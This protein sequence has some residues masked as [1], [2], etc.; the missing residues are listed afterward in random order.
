MNLRLQEHTT[1]LAGRHN[2][3]AERGICPSEKGAQLLD[4]SQ[5]GMLPRGGHVFWHGK[6]VEAWQRTPFCVKQRRAQA[7]CE[8][9]SCRAPPQWSEEVLI[10]QHVDEK[11]LRPTEH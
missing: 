8:E 2:D 5:E 6:V 9:A 3:R 4:G 7:F 1:S 10:R 11:T